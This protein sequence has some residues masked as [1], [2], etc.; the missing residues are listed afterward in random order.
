MKLKQIHKDMRLHERDQVSFT[1]LEKKKGRIYIYST[2]LS[3]NVS[4]SL[5]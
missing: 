3:Q 1:V 5:L 4:K 2:F